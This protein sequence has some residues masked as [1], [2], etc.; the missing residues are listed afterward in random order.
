MLEVKNLVFSYPD[1]ES[2]W[3]FH[4][5]VEPGQ[6]I[7]IHGASGSGKSTLMNLLAGFLEP[8]SGDILWQDESLRQ[9]APWQRPFTSVFQ[10]HNL[11][12]HLNVETNIGLG[13]HP[14]LKLTPENQQAIEQGLDSVGLEGFGKRLPGDLSGGQRQRVALL[15]ALLRKKPILLL[16]EPLTGLDSEARDLLRQLLLD[17]KA[18]GT[19]IVLASHDKE[20]R[21]LLADSVHR[22]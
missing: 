7:A 13:I 19:L 15:R 14:G 16:D 4:F 21:Q 3:N 9:Q 22:L 6:C 2:P 20:D 12:E 8:Q 5:T 17:E 11:F 18:R 10:E 1:Q